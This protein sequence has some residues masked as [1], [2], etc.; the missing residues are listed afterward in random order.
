MS[1]EKEVSEELSRK[2]VIKI[3]IKGM[4]LNSDM[5]IDDIA[6]V[7]NMPTEEVESI[8]APYASLRS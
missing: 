3:R 7:L 4:W 2:E 8:I 5:S 6:Y 1:K